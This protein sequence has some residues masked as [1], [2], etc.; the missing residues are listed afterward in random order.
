[1]QPL[2]SH[3]SAT[4]QPRNMSQMPRSSPPSYSTPL[5]SLLLS[6]HGRV[7]G[8][9]LSKASIVAPT[10]L[11]SRANPESEEA[12]LMGKFS[13][14]RE[15][16]IRWRFFAD[17]VNRQVLPPLV[18]VSGDDTEGMSPVLGTGKRR[19]GTG[20]MGTD[21]LYQELERVA[22]SAHVGSAS[23]NSQTSPPGTNI[24]DEGREA[25]S[26][27]QTS[28]VHPLRPQPITAHPFS[29]TKRYI[30]RRFAEILSRT[31]VLVEQGSSARPR[32]TISPQSLVGNRKAASQASNSDVAWIERSVG[33]E[34]AS[35]LAGR[36]SKKARER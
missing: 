29:R 24:R 2:V 23:D 27:L 8:K 4:T 16:N 36:P 34:K 3:S 18:T 33:L 9:G 11:P 31:P 20:L 15:V 26:W 25:P 19:K 22:V 5:S 32:V 12:R 35:I 6:P 1:M 7:I 13:L 21:V 17:E 30:R 14:R 10:S 28:Q